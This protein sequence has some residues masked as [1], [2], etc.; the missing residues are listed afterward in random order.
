MSTKSISQPISKTYITAK[1][2]TTTEQVIISEWKFVRGAKRCQAENLVNRMYFSKQEVLEKAIA[3][4]QIFKTST[5]NVVRHR[6]QQ[7][8]YFRQNKSR[9][10]S[11]T[12]THKVHYKVA[13][14]S[15]EEWIRKAQNWLFVQLY[16]EQMQVAV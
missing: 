7:T 8:V 15:F 5:T 13:S 11:L 10:T 1:F 14:S 16:R 9:R 3:K 4:K 12:Q 2:D 6:Q